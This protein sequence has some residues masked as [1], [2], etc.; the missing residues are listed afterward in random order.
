MFVGY[1]LFGGDVDCWCVVC[2]A[3]W[4]DV[5]CVL[6]CMRCWLCMVVRCLVVCCVLCVLFVCV[7][8]CCVCLCIVCV[9]VCYF[10]VVAI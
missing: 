6:V 7:C 4:S 2:A 9:V 5:L 1:E 10:V 8:V 3:G